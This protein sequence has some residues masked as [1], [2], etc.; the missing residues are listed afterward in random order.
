MIVCHIEDGDVQLFIDLE[1]IAEHLHAPGIVLPGKILIHEK[2]F[3]LADDSASERYPLLVRVGKRFDLLVQNVCESEKFGGC[4]YP[5]VDHSPREISEPQT[6]RHIIICI[7]MAVQGVILKS[8]CKAPV[9][10]KD[11]VEQI[12]AQ[13]DLAGSDILQTADHAQ[14]RRLAAAARPV[15]DNKLAVFYMKIDVIYGDESVWVSFSQVL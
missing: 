5:A 1:Y 9:A 7:K 11:I 4:F 14:D 10:G 2:Y 12:I 6:E 3:R 13:P 8:H 15:K